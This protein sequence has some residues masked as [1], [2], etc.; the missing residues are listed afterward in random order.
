MIYKSKLYNVNVSKLILLF[1][2]KFHVLY[3]I[4]ESNKTIDDA[5]H[6]LFSK[7]V[8]DQINLYLAKFYVFFDLVC[9]PLCDFI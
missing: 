5:F 6:L 7:I 1:V 3:Q 2:N 9:V 4:K 8:N